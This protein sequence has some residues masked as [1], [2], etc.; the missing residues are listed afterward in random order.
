MK[1]NVK[2]VLINKTGRGTFVPLLRAPPKAKK[3]SGNLK[4]KLNEANGSKVNT[5]AVN[6]TQEQLEINSKQNVKF[7][8]LPDPAPEEDYNF[9]PGRKRSVSDFSRFRPVAL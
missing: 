1:K 9:V 5:S 7:V 8:P 2:N 6:T 3:N 4:S